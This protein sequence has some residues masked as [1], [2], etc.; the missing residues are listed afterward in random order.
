MKWVVWYF[1][2]GPDYLLIIRTYEHMIT[3]IS[4]YQTQRK[5][6][7]VNNMQNTATEKIQMVKYLMN[8][9]TYKK[10]KSANQRT[11]IGCR[12]LK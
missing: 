9:K 3:K 8:R 12:T 4:D 2:L 6:T 10:K 5:I 11:D 1:P 7:C